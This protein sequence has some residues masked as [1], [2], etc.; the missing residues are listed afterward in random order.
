MWPIPDFRLLGGS[1]SASVRLRGGDHRDERFGV[2]C[3]I[4]DLCGDNPLTDGRN[5]LL[6]KLDAALDDAIDGMYRAAA[7]NV[8]ASLLNMA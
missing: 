1:A 6:P 5:R 2:V 7:P 3:L 8:S 4:G